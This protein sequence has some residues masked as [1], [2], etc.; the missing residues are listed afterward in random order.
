[1]IR[2][3]SSGPPY[4]DPAWAYVPG[5]TSR[6]PDGTFEVLCDTARPD[7]TARELSQTDAWLAGLQYLDRGFF[8]EAHEVIEP[9]WMAIPDGAP[10]RLVVQA[11]IQIANA[12]LKQKMERPG[13][14]LRLCAIAEALLADGQ[15]GCLTMGVRMQD[16]QDL[17]VTQRETAN[18]KTSEA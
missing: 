4:P 13:A 16:L 11:V 1:M 14:V 6:H 17:I 12:S 7:M 9:V 15:A 18:R 3:G 10:E 8:W 5:R 2:G